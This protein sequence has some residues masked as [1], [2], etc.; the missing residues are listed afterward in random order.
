MK[1]FLMDFQKRL[2]DVNEYVLEAKL[3]SSEE[4]M[5]E[6]ANATLLRAQR[7]VG[8]RPKGN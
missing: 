1:Q 2:E 7:A 6:I 8:L 5:N 4:A 3:A